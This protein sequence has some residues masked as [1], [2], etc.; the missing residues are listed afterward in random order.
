[1]SHILECKDLT[2]TY[3]KTT[4]ID[5]ISV[6]VESGRVVGLLGPKDS[7]KTTFLKLAAGLLTP[8]SG[9]IRID[10][11]APGVDTK[12][13]TA[14]LGDANAFEDWASVGDAFRLYR[15]FYADFDCEKALS[16]LSDLG[17]EHKEKLKEMSRGALEKLG[18]ALTM[19]R[20]A[21]LFLLDEPIGGLDPATRDYVFNNVFANRP[22]GSTVIISAGTASDV[23]RVLQDAAF[24]SNG[25]ITL[26]EDAENLRSE[27][28]KSL[29]AIFREEFK[30]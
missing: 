25:R 13:F 7:G 11:V 29:D 6:S 21:K 20:R 27:R 12:K 4:A 17:I 5:G 19:S 16:M 24:I 15:D 8:D 3:G 2:K 9:E 23:E 1:M 10:G 30:C 28:G 14:F 22:D 26:F 18:I